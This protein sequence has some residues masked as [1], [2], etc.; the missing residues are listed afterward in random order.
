MKT[1]KCNV[2]STCMATWVQ[3][4]SGMHLRTLLNGIGCVLANYSALTDDQAAKLAFAHLILSH[5]SSTF[6]DVCCCT[7]VG[8]FSQ[9]NTRPVPLASDPAGL[10]GCRRESSRLR[11]A[12]DW[13]KRSPNTRRR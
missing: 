3:D 5:N 13:L 10:S 12:S 7:F 1:L 2:M 4:Y 11:S 9:Q 8:N 6:V